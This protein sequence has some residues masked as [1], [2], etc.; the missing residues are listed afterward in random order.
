MKTSNPKDIYSIPDLAPVWESR[1]TQ[2]L[3]KPW[4]DY[5]AIVAEIYWGGR[6]TNNYLEKV[7]VIVLAHVEIPFIFLPALLKPSSK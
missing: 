7:V 4:R 2:R 1:H 6:M 5:I 3:V